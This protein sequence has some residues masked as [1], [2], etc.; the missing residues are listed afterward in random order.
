M[1]L[2]NISLALACMVWRYDF[3]LAPSTLGHIEEGRADSPLGRQC[4]H[5]FQLKST[6]TSLGDGP[7]L[8]FREKCRSIHG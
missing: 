3:Q 1:A 5:N 2:G 7:Y 6:I 8:I 4:V